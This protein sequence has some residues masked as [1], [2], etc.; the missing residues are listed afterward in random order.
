MRMLVGSSVRCT[1]IPASKSCRASSAPARCQGVSVSNRRPW[2]RLAKGWTP[3]V[4]TRP[5]SFRAGFTA[6]LMAISGP[7]ARIPN[8]G[9]PTIQILTN[10]RAGTEGVSLAIGVLEPALQQASRQIGRQLLSIAALR[11]GAHAPT[12]AL[13]ADPIALPT[14]PYR[15]LPGHA[16]LG[17]SA[18]YIALL[19]MLVGFLG[20]IVVNSS[21]DAALGYAPTEI[22]PRW[23][24]R[25]PVAISRWQTLLTKWV[26]ALVLTAVLCGL[27]LL[28]AVGAL[29][30]DAPSIGY[31]WLF[32]WFASATVAAGTLVLFAVLGAPGQ[33]VA[34]LLFVYLGLASAGSTVPIQ[35]LP[36][37]LRLVTTG[38]GTVFWVAAGV[39]VIMAYDRKGLFRLNPETLAYVDESVRARRHQSDH[40]AGPGAV[41][42]PPWSRQASRR[43]STDHR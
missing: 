18:F 5:S 2:P 35:A 11:G 24:Q 7:P 27:M 33:L 16:G 1:S 29:G 42:Q 28:V 21:V 40:G 8:P 20:A 6:S 39:L 9:K 38:A 13:L 31:L 12:N 34:L 3:V 19:T 32:T 25:Q 14:V 36:S 43:R 41:S 30:M 17:L 26:I 15:P 23:S 4:P 37:S 22:G 10:Q